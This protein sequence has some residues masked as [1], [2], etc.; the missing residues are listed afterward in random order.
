MDTYTD[1]QCAQLMACKDE[2]ESY[3]YRAMPENAMTYIL[4]L[5]TL[6][7]DNPLIAH[8]LAHQYGQRCVEHVER[9][10]G[11]FERARQHEVP[12]DMPS[13]YMADFMHFLPSDDVEY[14]DSIA[15]QLQEGYAL[16]L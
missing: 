14:R 11:I 3:I 1:E 9:S 7:G 16:F 12:Q 4:D 8:Y 2:H 13:D 5:M 6:V 15:L 10:M